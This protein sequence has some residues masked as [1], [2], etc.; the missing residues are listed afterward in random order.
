MTL[1][2]R[3][4]LP[5]TTLDISPLCLGGN[6]LGGDLDEYAS[7]ALLDAFVEHGG[8][9]IDTAH[10]YADWLPH[11]ERSCSEKTIGR[12][13]RMCGDAGV[14]IATKGGH[15]RL[16]DPNVR[17][18]DAASLRQDVE[19]ALRNLGVDTLDLFYLH[20]DDPS[21][22][23]E[24]ILASLEALRREGLIRHV[25]ASNW[26]AARLAEA[27]A[28][29]KA[30]GWQSFCANQC[31]W[32]LARR[33]PGSASGDLVAMDQE[34]LHWHRHTQV[35]AVPYSS[36]AK[37]YFEKR[38]AGKLDEV[39]ARAYDG[40]ANRTMSEELGAIASALSATPTQ[41]M[42]R[43]LTLSPFPTIPVVGCRDARQVA[44]SAAA[45]AVPLRS[46]TAAALLA[47]AERN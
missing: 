25:A 12:W 2:D 37:G 24:A 5:G 22:A 20:R 23:V 32:S 1:G 38:A 40:K 4:R 10:V 42:L 8:N 45:L 27:A 15:P 29:S 21:R 47:M 28:V 44:E 26:S 17:R 36:Q 43:A 46:D 6:R 18:L 35:A 31:E 41:V 9:F 30:R 33:N 3:V 16:D 39:T 34:L 13:L 19:E 7:F 11:A 14:V